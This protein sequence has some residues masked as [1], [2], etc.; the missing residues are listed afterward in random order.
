MAADDLILDDDDW[1]EDDDEEA[2]NVSPSDY[3]TITTRGTAT[4]SPCPSFSRSFVQASHG[5]INFGNSDPS[6]GKLITQFS[7]DPVVSGS[8]HGLVCDA[9]KIDIDADQFLLKFGSSIPASGTLQVIT[10]IKLEVGKEIHWTIE[11]LPFRY[12]IC[13]ASR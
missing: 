2:S 5:S 6:S 4:A 7:I 10:N 3:E 9:K 13:V 8:D 1:D 12:G 11:K